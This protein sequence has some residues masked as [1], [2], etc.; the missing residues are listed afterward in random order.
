MIPLLGKLA[1]GVLQ[2]EEQ[3]QNQMQQDQ[4]NS[5][6]ERFSGWTKQ[7]P[8]WKRMAAKGQIENATSAL[9]SSDQ[10]E[11]ANAAHIEAANAAN[12][13]IQNK[14]QAALG[15]GEQFTAPEMSYGTPSQQPSLGG[16]W[17]AVKRNPSYGFGG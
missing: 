3:R 5:N 12:E 9:Q 11:A 2:G 8:E 15:Q 14:L 1:I 13:D 4:M 17:S 16:S 10:D 6:V 7:H